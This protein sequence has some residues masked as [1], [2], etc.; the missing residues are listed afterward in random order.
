M[1]FIR[2]THAKINL[3]NL[4][5]NF[6]LI[7]NKTK[8]TTK[9]I[10]VIK[11]NAYGHGAVEC[12]KALVKAG[13]DYL[14]VATIE[15]GIELRTAGIKIPI[16]VLG[17]IYPYESFEYIV[18][19]K[20]TPSISSVGLAKKLSM[21]SK[22]YNK[23]TPIHIKVDTGMGRIGMAISRAKQ[24]IENIS[25][26]NHVEIEGVYTHF[27]GGINNI[28]QINNFN[29]LKNSLSHLKIPYFHAS[30]SLGFLKYSEAEYN[31]I[32]PGIALYGLIDGNTNLKPVL[33][34]KSKIVFLKTISQGKGISYGHIYKTYKQTV[35]A[36]IP[37]GY[38]DGYNRLLS[39]SAE[40]IVKGIRVPQIGRI[41]MD[42]CMFDVTNV[43]NVKVG[44]EITLI[45]K[46]GNEEI[47]VEDI[48]KQIGSITYEVVC[49][50]S[51]RVPRIY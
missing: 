40:G 21:Y 28:N 12:G 43:K 1:H 45:G 36:T 51:S 23:K 34:L 44:D 39:N 2:P 15:E 5:H 6:H 7:K 41:C 26:L 49:Q 47:K 14:G 32:R 18:K 42:M 31:M 35:V 22:K 11:A 25:K 33:S 17:S 16:L 10:S 50:I 30:N 38:A 9:I 19:Y 24:Y 3:Q 13:T 48:A 27:S 37:I 8:K 29:T 4:V 20:L 46:S